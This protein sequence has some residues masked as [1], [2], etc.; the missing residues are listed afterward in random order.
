MNIMVGNLIN[1][2][3]LG[4]GNNQDG[5][6]NHRVTRIVRNHNINHSLIRDL[7][8]GALDPLVVDPVPSKVLISNI[9][10]TRDLNGLVSIECDV[11]FQR[12]TPE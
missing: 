11:T 1:R 12:P 9:E 2:D 10:I 3:N 7:I 8:K 6:G 4:D 5:F